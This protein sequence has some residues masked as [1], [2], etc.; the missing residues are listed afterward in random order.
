MATPTTSIMYQP[1]ADAVAEYMR[2]QEATLREL[3]GRWI[4]EL[5]PCVIYD[6][7]D[8]G[9]EI[10]GIGM[11]RDPD[12]RVIIANPDYRPRPR[13]TDFIYARRGDRVESIFRWSKHQQDQ[14]G[15]PPFTRERS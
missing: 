2:R 12:G 14:R 5:E 7:Q 8:T 6:W 4:S 11:A 3:L 13:L 10:K 15:R 9:A 1:L